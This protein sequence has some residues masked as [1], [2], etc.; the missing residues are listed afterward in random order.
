M[1]TASHIVRILLGLIFTVFGLNG[2]P[3]KSR[4]MDVVSWRSKLI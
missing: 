3:L 2:H 4:R 1:R